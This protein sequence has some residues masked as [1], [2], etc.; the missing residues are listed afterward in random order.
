MTSHTDCCGLSLCR[1]P[2]HPSLIA[3]IN[4]QKSKMEAA[5]RGA[6]PMRAA[7]RVEA[8]RPGFNDGL[9]IP[10][11]R[12]PAGTSL[13]TAR[14]QAADRAP[15]RGTVRIIVVLVEF[16]DQAIAQPVAHYERLFF[17]QGQIPSGSVREYFAEVS[18]SAI[19]VVGQVVGP[20]K[21]PKTLAQYA[22]SDSGTGTAFPN[23]RTMAAYALQAANADVNFA[24]FDN[25]GNG[26]VDAFIVV[27]AGP[28]A[29]VTGNPGDIWS[30][31]WVLPSEAAVD[32]TRVFAYLTIPDDARIGVC[33]HEIGHL[34]FG[35]PDLYD[36][37]GSSE[38]L[39]NWCLMAGGSWNNNG[40]TPAHPS[41][42]CKAQ[43]GWVSVDNR[44]TN[45]NVTV[46]SVQSSHTVL[47]LWKNGSPGQEYFLVENRRKT[48][49]DAHLPGEGLLVFHVDE[50]IDGNSDEAHPQVALAQADGKNQL[51]NGS[52]RGDGGDCYPGQSDNRSF[53]AASNPSSR[54]YGG[55]DTCVSITS[56]SASASSMTA[57][58]SVRCKAK[59]TFG[60]KSLL[61]EKIEKDKL[62]HE[63]PFREKPHL[64]DFEKPIT[65]KMS[66]YEKPPVFEKGFD[67][68]QDGGFGFGG[69]P[70]AASEGSD[71]LAERVRELESVV[72]SIRPFIG[73]ELR[74]DLRAG[75]LIEEDDV[76][77][78]QTEMHKGGAQA[79]RLYDTKPRET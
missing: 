71:A 57:R 15:L 43:Q 7:L 40:D 26:Y 78:V 9:I 33:C 14:R 64:K 70:R 58:V 12:A 79:K 22:H 36:T 35:W 25:D 28:G 65:D 16:S 73:Q 61:K 44:T 4:E 48:N 31:K 8:S 76:E 20:Y 77:A 41:A 2:P 55:V 67:K 10:G 51:G 45:G 27:H 23:A 32:G 63:K 3:K 62:E 6:V 39:G 56:I 53:T 17:S 18:N 1:M 11:E 37:D 54:S 59:E 24:P 34:V 52:N 66:G 50:S 19:D 74:P 72:A 38:G 42:W 5:G 49:F 46:D 68:P 69:P 21:L 13:R 75:A 47:R 60:G 29:E 30:H